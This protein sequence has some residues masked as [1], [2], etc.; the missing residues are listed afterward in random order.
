MRNALVLLAVLG[1]ITACKKA[2][3]INP[4]PPPGSHPAMSYV[5]L[6]G[7]AVSFNN[8]K[9]LDLDKN[10][11]YDI[12]F[13]TMLVGDPIYQVDKRQWLVNSSFNTSLPVKNE[14]IPVMNYGD[15]IPVKKFSGYEWY[16]ASGIVLAQ[17]IISFTQNPYWVGEWKAASHQYLP[18]QLKINN[19]L[20]NGWIEISFSSADEKVLLH[21]AAVC[22]EAN[23]GIIA[24]R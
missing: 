11:Q 20:F 10:G 2:K 22:L 18:I 23:M 13:S 6:E 3:P 9:I 21:K 12:V 16:N 4:G 8:Y 24:G 15:S 17:Q 5:D 7:D 19:N 1:V 14:T